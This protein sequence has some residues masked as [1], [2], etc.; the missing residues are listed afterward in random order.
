M[1]AEDIGSWIEPS[2]P[3]VAP[4][5]SRIAYVVTTVDLDGNCYRSRIWLAAA[6]GSTSPRPIT[7]GEHRDRLPRWS[8]DGS[9][10]AFV[11]HRHEPGS[12][13][14]L[15]RLDGGEPEQ[16]LSWP[17]EISHVA[18]SPR[19]DRIAIVTRQRDEAQYAPEKDRDRPPRRITRLAYRHDGEGFTADRLPHVFTVAISDH[20][21]VQVTTGDFAHT[22]PA[23]LDDDTIVCSA[24][25]T[26][27]W[28]V[29]LA[30]DLYAFAADGTGEPRRLTTC[31]GTHA[32]PVVC[33]D[34]S[35]A[36]IHGDDR[37]LPTHN[38][39]VVHGDDALTR[40]LDRNVTATRVAC[41]GNDLLFTA[42]DHGNVPLLR[43]GRSGGPP[44]T[45]I[46]GTHRVTGYAA[47]GGTIAATLA[48]PDRFTQLVV[49]DGSRVRTLTDFVV[50]FDVVVPEHLEVGDV[51]A[52]LLRP[53]G[54]GPFPTL[55][56]IHGGPFTQYGPMLFDELQVQVAAGY[57]VL[58]C[59]PRG[60]SG[61]T[62]AWGRAIRG[63]RAAVSPG[64]GWGGVDAE[65][66]L[67]VVDAA[68]ERHPDV[69][70]AARIGVLGGSYGG[71]MT[72]WLI[73]HT[74]RFVAACA[75]RA[76]TNM[77]TFAHSS[78]IGPMFPATYVGASHLDDPDEHVRQSPVTY[79][80]Q[81][82]TPL[83][84]LHSERDLRCPIEQ[85]E[86]LFVRLKLLGRD[87]E[88]ARMPGEGHELSRSGAPLHRV[89]RFRLILDFFA[90]HL[91]H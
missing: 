42:D 45:V 24:S 15:L 91:S 38:Q 58:A 76:L 84:L 28:D 41:D 40:A 79:A 20:A 34:G 66:I 6:D 33:P 26:D 30:V 83:L 12:E 68:I 17:E 53:R 11:S 5:G 57:A 2:D 87:V 72:S 75:E 61:S 51:D 16:L 39:I 9:A 82:T 80:D 55:L 86:D 4:G 89:Q 25:R 71:Y 50:P 62:E 21:L 35:I 48:S 54:T 88:L 60:S 22:D 1:Q 63:P 44:T 18:W 49:V 32:A 59:N 52:W 31:G 85:A 64:S 69:V 10:L 19:G 13:L 37:V 43:I 67:A 74:G 81:I 29:D 46:G 23:W 65:D 56:N 27:T 36:Y 7:A 70:D 47:A 78:D 77:V 14:Y 3:A 8:P 90:R 73:G